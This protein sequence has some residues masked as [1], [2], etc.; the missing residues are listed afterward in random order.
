MCVCVCGWVCGWMGGVECVRVCVC[1]CVCGG[2][3]VGVGV[4]AYGCVWHQVRRTGKFVGEW[5]RWGGGGGGGGAAEN[6]RDA[7]SISRMS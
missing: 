5:K 4:R 7:S 6:E 3:G 1:Q 2:G